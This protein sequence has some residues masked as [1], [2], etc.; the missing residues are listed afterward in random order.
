[1]R[2]FERN[3]TIFTMFEKNGEQ[4]LC[5]GNPT[6]ELKFDFAGEICDYCRVVGAT[7][8]VSGTGTIDELYNEWLEATSF[9]RSIG[10][11]F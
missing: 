11:Q 9:Y 1:M 3:G 8:V 7:S 6:G 4:Y 5:T 10:I 2:K